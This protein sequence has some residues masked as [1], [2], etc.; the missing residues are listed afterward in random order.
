LVPN[1]NALDRFISRLN[2]YFLITTCIILATAAIF[3]YK[4]ETIATS[5]TN[6]CNKVVVVFAAFFGWELKLGCGDGKVGVRQSFHQNF[7]STLYF[8]HILSILVKILERKLNFFINL[9]KN[10]SLQSP[11]FILFLLN[12]CHLF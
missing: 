7:L 6:D 11:N 8:F 4:F 12:A 5:M 3:H 10:I 9:F 1:E 2:A